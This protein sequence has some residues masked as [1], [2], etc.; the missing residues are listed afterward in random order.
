MI[1]VKKYHLVIPNKAT[2][3]RWLKDTIEV[4]FLGIKIY[5]KKIYSY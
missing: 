5:T 4:Y 1:L 2:D 3:L